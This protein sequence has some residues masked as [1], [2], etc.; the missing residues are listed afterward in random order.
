MQCQAICTSTRSQCSRTAKFVCDHSFV[1]SIHNRVA[2]KK[3]DICC[4]CL[5]P[6]DKKNIKLTSCHH[7]HHTECLKGW[8]SKNE[9]CPL[10]RHSIHV[11]DLMKIYKPS[12]LKIGTLV[13]SVSLDKRP[14][15]IHCIEKYLESVL[16][17]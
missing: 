14:E 13:F 10:C 4:I 7:V 1:C 9:S 2:Q 6:L 5:L 16:L 8:V 11:Q 12:V 3:D 17:S 15:V